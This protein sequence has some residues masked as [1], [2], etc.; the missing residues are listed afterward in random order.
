MKTYYIGNLKPS[1]VVYL[2]SNINNEDIREDLIEKMDQY[3]SQG[4]TCIASLDEVFCNAAMLRNVL[5]TIAD[6]KLSTVFKS[7]IQ[8][9][10][11]G[12]ERSAAFLDAL[13][14]D[15]DIKFRPIIGV[16][17]KFG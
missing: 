2:E 12:K 4:P 10:D 1:D 3:L 15:R 13:G 6:E 11:Q 14:K 9:G 7:V 8:T 17:R 5:N 16:A